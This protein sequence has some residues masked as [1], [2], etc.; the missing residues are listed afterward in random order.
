MGGVFKQWSYY[1]QP[2]ENKAC[3]SSEC[4]SAQ[5]SNPGGQGTKIT[6]SI[7][8]YQLN[9]FESV[10]LPMGSGA[11]SWEKQ[12]GKIARITNESDEA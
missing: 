8:G 1:E 10:S 2:I 12:L 6:E 5:A 11:D 9:S 4:K 7:T 3:S